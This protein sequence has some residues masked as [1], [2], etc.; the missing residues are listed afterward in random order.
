MPLLSTI[1]SVILLCG[2][3][4]VLS[5]CNSGQ[6]L[7]IASGGSFT[8]AKISSRTLEHPQPKLSLEEQL[9]WAVGKSF[10]KQAWVSAPASTTARDGLGPIFNANSCIACHK[11]NGQGLLPDHGPGLILRIAPV[12]LH[13]KSY[14]EQLQDHATLSSK[15]EGQI[16]WRE[17][18]L[19]SSANGEPLNL[20]YRQYFIS[21]PR[22]GNTS[23][24]AVSARLAPAL[25]GLGLLDGIPDETVIA[26]S[27]PD[28]RDQNGISGRVAMHW[29]EQR[30]RLRPGRFGW[31]ASQPSLL[32]QIALAFSQDI[33]IRSPIY[34]DANCPGNAINCDKELSEDHNAEPEISAKLLA[35]VT[36]YIG[37]LAVPGIQN[38]PDLQAGYQVFIDIGCANCHIPATQTLINPFSMQPLT[39]DTTFRKETIYPFS[40]LL[41]HDMGSA[42]ADSADTDN[43]PA[44]EW[45]TAP[46]WGLGLRSK[47]ED[48]TRLL[49][50]GR[51]NSVHTAILWHGGEAKVSR[52]N[53]LQ[54]NEQAQT[55]LLNFLKAL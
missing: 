34:P 11:A 33:G 36:A 54:L 32:Q 31:K 55:T 30:Q 40:D 7:P 9:D 3:A 45:R 37:N 38:N 16:A 6:P 28:D 27:D 15:A 14:G 50:D 2:S 19:S 49:H 24:M 48:N 21:E 29:D 13:H 51:A 41:L 42:L 1:L 20:A 26:L 43:T 4:I 47:Q 44:S 12:G 52:K 25:I 22:Y 39:G 23:D 46:L 35:A 8:E 5:A 18:S 10:A 17:V 53:Y